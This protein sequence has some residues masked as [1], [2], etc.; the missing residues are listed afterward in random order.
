M[1]ETPTEAP[2]PTEA[3]AQEAKPEAP[4]ID[5]KAKAREW[6]KRAKDNKAAADELAQMKESSKTEAERQ[7]ER[8]TKAEAEV[9]QVPAKVADALKSHL[10]TLHEITD[11]D[12]ELFLTANDP[13]LLLKQVARLMERNADAS[14]PRAPRP[15]P[16]QGKSPAPVSLD[17]RA[18]D[19]AQIE[20]D[21]AKAR[22]R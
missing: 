21:L 5:W 19:L 16:N 1:S 17:P 3:P 13:D 6:E 14:K 12:A 4:E 8:I 15:D 18:A 11:E 20:A 7:A 2:E 22:R 10:V 9:A